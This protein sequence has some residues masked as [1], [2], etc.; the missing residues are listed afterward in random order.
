MKLV[1]AGT[2][3]ALCAAMFAESAHARGHADK[4]NEKKEKKNIVTQAASPNG[5]HSRGQ[6][7]CWHRSA[8]GE[9]FVWKGGR[10]VPMA[11]DSVNSPHH[12]PTV[13]TADGSPAAGSAAINHPPARPDVVNGL[14]WYLNGR[15][16]TSE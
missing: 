14:D 7:R 5:G 4:K 8:G 12:A 16:Y 3:L 2:L 15:G 6:G 11:A 10:W 13:R 1:A 9:L